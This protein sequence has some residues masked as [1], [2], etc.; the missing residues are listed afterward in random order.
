MAAYLFPLVTSVDRAL[1]RVKLCRVLDLRR[2]ARHVH[3]Y[4]EVT[5]EAGESPRPVDL[6]F[7]NS[8]IA[9]AVAR[10]SHRMIRLGQEDY[11][12][13]PSPVETV[14]VVCINSAFVVNS[15]KTG[16]KKCNSVC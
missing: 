14:E 2:T 13:L 3:R 11:S 9:I 8:S 10:R 15:K 1:C 7:V 12:S 5:H 16:A 4:V 6:P